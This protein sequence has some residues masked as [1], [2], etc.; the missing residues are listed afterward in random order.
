M[1]LFDIV[2]RYGIWLC[3][4]DCEYFL[5]YEDYPWFG[6]A[7]VND[8]LEVKLLHGHHVHWAAL[9]VDLELDCLKNP[10]RYPLVFKPA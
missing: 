3:V 7:K 2:S 5:P 1:A 6:Y 8:I 10:S 9:D 4:G